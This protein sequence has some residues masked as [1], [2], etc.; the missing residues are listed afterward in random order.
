MLF[1]RLL[2]VVFVGCRPRGSHA[3]H[4][5]PLGPGEPTAVHCLYR[6]RFP[7]ANVKRQ[8]FLQLVWARLA[9]TDG[10]GLQGAVRFALG[11]IEPSPS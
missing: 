3:G 9:A 5:P 1:E 6:E 7:M 8:S 4:P 11:P 10:T 2:Q